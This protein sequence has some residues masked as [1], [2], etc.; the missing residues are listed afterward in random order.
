MGDRKGR[1][2]RKL[3]ADGQVDARKS[4]YDE[5]WI[6]PPELP[7][8]EKVIERLIE[9]QQQG[10]PILTPPTILRLFADSFRGKK[11]PPEVMP[12]RVGLR[13]FFIRA[14]GRVEVCVHYPPIGNIREQSA[15]EIWHGPE[16][17][18]IRRQTVACDRLCLITCLSQKTLKD[19]V[20]MGVRLLK[21][22][23]RRRVAEEFAP[24]K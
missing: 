22:Q 13:D 7:E 23:K 5:L 20:N 16:A 9:M 1:E 10:A 3:P 8:L 12:C 4:L 17:Q 14:D 6:E 11:A 19:K 18:E 15:R 24:V 2:L 21:G